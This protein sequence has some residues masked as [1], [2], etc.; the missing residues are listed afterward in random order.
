MNNEKEEAMRIRPVTLWAL[1][2]VLAGC[3]ASPKGISNADRQAAMEFDRVLAQAVLSGDAAKMTSMYTDDAII[4]PPSSP[5]IQGRDAIQR[6]HES[7][8]QQGITQFD[9]KDIKIDGVGN[10]LVM[11]GES[12]IRC[13]GGA[14]SANCD[15]GKYM[16]ILNRQPDGQWKKSLAIWNSRP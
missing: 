16:C 4:M 5:T 9:L 2:L 7:F 3:A 11:A 8:V 13:K 12:T 10:M 14:P 6:F 15:N 1:S